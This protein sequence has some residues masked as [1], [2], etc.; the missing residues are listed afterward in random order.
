MSDL[1]F[2]RLLLSYCM[3]FTTSKDLLIMIMIAPR[4]GNA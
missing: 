3:M 1:N 4:F 2:P